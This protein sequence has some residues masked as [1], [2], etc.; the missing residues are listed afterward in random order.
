MRTMT[1]TRILVND[2][3]F[4]L[5]QGQDEGELKR[6]IE[7]AARAGGGF[8]EFV[9]VGNRVVSVFVSPSTHIVITVETVEFDARDT[10]DDAAP[11]GGEFDI[12]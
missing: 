12:I 9:V 10:G 2:V 3:G 4:F 1:R 8:V 6:R 7:V 11:F 5:A